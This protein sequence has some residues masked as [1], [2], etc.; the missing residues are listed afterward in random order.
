[1]NTKLTKKV[2]SNY[3]SP[4]Q[5]FKNVYVFSKRGFHDFAKEKTNFGV[6]VLIS[7]TNG[8]V[9]F[10]KAPIGDRFQEKD[11]HCVRNSE[12]H[13]DNSS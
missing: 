5:G 11:L 10:L 6:I 1:M 13:L 8:N 4:V 9:L 3:L 12:I 7:I 2:I